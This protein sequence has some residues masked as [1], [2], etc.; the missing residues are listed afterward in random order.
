[1]RMIYSEFLA[2]LTDCPFC[3]TS[4]RIVAENEYAFLT[5][6]IAPYRPDHLLVIPKQHIEHV[7][8]LSQEITND[9]DS[10]QRAGLRLLNRLGHENVT[11]LVREGM[12][13]G[14]SIPHLH[15]HLVPD[16][17]LGDTERNGKERSVLADDEIDSL[18]SR[19]T[20][21]L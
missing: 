12:G 18:V 14:K 10:L 2:T 4:H 17:L 15:Y 7:L 19:L 20:S 21:A 5:Y 13:S 16:I 1:M 6:A 9:L 11:L 3:A 8:E